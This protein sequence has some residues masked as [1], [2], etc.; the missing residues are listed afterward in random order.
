MRHAGA[1]ALCARVKRTSSED[2]G[3]RQSRRL[4]TNDHDVSVL[5][6]TLQFLVEQRNLSFKR[7][8]RLIQFREVVF[9]YR[10]QFVLSPL[11]QRLAHNF[12][13]IIL[14]RQSRRLFVRKRA[15]IETKIL[16]TRLAQGVGV[17]MH[18]AEFQRCGRA[19]AAVERILNY[20]YFLQLPVNV[21]FHSC[22]LA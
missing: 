22:R 17:R 4:L 2:V 13:H 14:K 20:R 10:V 18:A 16:K 12:R 9:T 21:K 8:R 5:G 7:T 19:G 3:I 1:H 15:L 11:G 6:E